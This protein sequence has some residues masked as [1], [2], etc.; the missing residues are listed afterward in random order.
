MSTILPI[1]ER[2]RIQAGRVESLR[3][4]IRAKGDN[5]SDRYS[6]RVAEQELE[7]TLAEL[8]ALSS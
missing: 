1:D 7:A 3:E 4:K 5:A 2:L 6:L 8:K